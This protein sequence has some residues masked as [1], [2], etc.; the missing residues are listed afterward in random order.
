MEFRILGPLEVLHD[1]EAMRLPGRVQPRLLAVLLL[2]A[3]RVVPLGRI[4]DAVWDADPP[5]TARRQV[6]NNTAMLRRLLGD[7][8]TMESVGEGY[9]VRVDEN[10]LDALRFEAT[11]RTAR[12]QNRA[13]DSKAALATLQTGL[14][15]WRG[16]ALAG[17]SGRLIES[18]AARLDEARVAAIEERVD[19]Q[20]EAGRTHAV[21]AE[22]R[23]LLARHPFRERLAGQLMLAL[24]RDGRAPEAL[25][26]YET[27][28]TRLVQE[29]GMDPGQR[30][31]DLH[32]AILREDAVLDTSRPRRD[33]RSAGAG[34][35]PAMPAPKQLP[36]DTASFTGREA[37]LST[38]D[39]LLETGESAA[40]LSAV[41]GIG[42][43]GK[44]ALAVHWG[45]RV[46][47]RFRDGQL[48]VNLRGFD[49]GEPLSVKAALN[50]FLRAL[51]QSGDA[52][53]ETV[54]EAAGLYR[55]LLAGKRILVVLDN[56]RDVAQVRPLLPGSPG[57]FA[58]VT[59]RNRLAG[60]SALDDAHPLPLDT[61]GQA[62]CLELLAD[63]LGAD[64]LHVDPAAA[65]RLAELCGRLPLAMRIAAANLAA[66]T[67]TSVADFVAE[68]ERT[69]R[70]ELLA[71]D[72]DPDSAVATAFDR[73]YR[74]LD[75]ATQDL[76]LR[77]GL[78]PGYD[79]APALAA[80]I[81][82][83][84]EPHTRRLLDGLEN[85]H[86][87]EQHQ[88]GRY[89]Y[90]DL[91]REYA[92]K[93]AEAALNDSD[94]GT[95]RDRAVDWY[96]AQRNNLSSWEY[97]NVVAA[98]QTWRRHPPALRLVRTLAMFADEGHDVA[99]VRRHVD[100]GLDV[101]RQS[102][103][104][105]GLY[106]VSRALT[107]INYHAGDFSSAIE[108]GR[109]VVELAPPDDS[110]VRTNLGGFLW[111]AGQYA[112]AE[113]WLREALRVVESA[114][115][116][117]HLVTVL[118]NLG[119]VCHGLSKFDEAETHLKRSIRTADELSKTSSQTRNRVT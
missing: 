8:A 39:Q 16:P 29:L 50:S 89:R 55:S 95:V 82:D 58:L 97:D 106:H 86:L 64:R 98:F 22:L 14:E 31:R 68:L 28:R 17:L 30:L 80:A 107:I 57:S 38:L 37:Q 90:H 43:V 6:Q 104:A 3:G 70:L 101:A 79:F 47:E 53:P 99:E 76:F 83:R 20:L 108:H 74:A 49:S 73:S 110:A 113:T 23:E 85:A 54:D 7:G 33:R 2:E 81:A 48:Y 34:G 118:S 5:D 94:R 105:D 15:L 1:G 24:Y 27:V 56:A 111:A 40:V 10:Q 103:D 4:V 13:G 46:R 21:I 67:H 63:L 12:E 117:E 102:D 59:S 114:D 60:L 72:G 52:I 112:E 69:D 18:G 96:F 92:R 116:K 26:V 91:I 66:E 78:V 100:A 19:L 88:P 65:K 87:V 42:G 36:A 93:S 51:G 109:K 61:L 84:P 32:G 77:L 41:A 115:K 45:H 119:S 44:T 75:S 11:V 71:V 35:G 62:D 25:D 9:R